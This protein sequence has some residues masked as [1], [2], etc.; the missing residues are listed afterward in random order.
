MSVGNETGFGGDEVT[1][2]GRTSESIRPPW[3]SGGLKEPLEA[4]FPGRH[5][6]LSER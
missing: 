6:T 4:P 2:L 1:T 3:R 5:H